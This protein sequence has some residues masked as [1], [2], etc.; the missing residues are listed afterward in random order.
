MILQ[1][2]VTLPSQN[3]DGS[4]MFP[5][6]WIETWLLMPGTTEVWLLAALQPA[7]L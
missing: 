4:P 6:V 7:V 5:G 1:N 2:F 3:R